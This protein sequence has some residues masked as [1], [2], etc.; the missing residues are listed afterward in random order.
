AL[1]DGGSV[2]D[3]G[4][5]GGA[6]SLPLAPPAGRVIGVDESEGMLDA[7]RQAAS[8]LDVR[9]VLGRWPD[10]AADVGSADLAV[11]HHVLYNVQDLEPFVRALDDHAR[12]RVVLE[13]TAQHPLAW[14]SDLWLRFHALVRPVGPTSAD[15]ARALSE[16]GYPVRHEIETRRPRS[17]GFERRDDAIS[18]VRR[19]LCLTADRDPEIADA[20]GDRLIERDGLWSAGPREQVVATLWWDV[21][22][23]ND[24]RVRR[25]T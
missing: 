25:A 14:M 12:R 15:A 24:Q 20:L 23:S 19:R 17:S 1:P 18:L 2:L 6:A 21:S 10:V 8:G 3:I 11:S 22:P 9:T 7:F 5:G 16:L 13:I 4:V